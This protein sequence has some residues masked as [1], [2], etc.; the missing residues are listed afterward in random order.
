LITNS[1]HFL[2]R[3][4]SASTVFYPWRLYQIFASYKPISSTEFTDKIVVLKKVMLII[5][6]TNTKSFQTN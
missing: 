5:W 4:Y 2:M 6:K 1:V 3:H